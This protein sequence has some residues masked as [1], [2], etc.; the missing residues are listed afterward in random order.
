MSRGKGPVNYFPH[1]LSATGIIDALNMSLTAGNRLGPYEILSLIG[2]GGMGEVYKARDSRLD[3]IVAVKISK[4]EFDPRFEREALAV[5]ALN[6]PHIC[7]LF[8][9]GPHYLVMEYVEGVELAGPMPLAKAIPLACQ[10]LDALDAAHCRGIIHRDLKPANV[11]VTR[12]GVKVLDF[13]LAKIPEPREAAFDHTKSLI[14]AEGMVAG[15]VHYMSPEHMQGRHVDSRADIFAF[16]CVLHELLTG[17]RAFEGAD[18]A[19]VIA[20][21]IEGPTPSVATVAP[22]AL[23]RVLKKCL[24]K[25]R[26]DRWNCARDLKTQL[27]WAC[28]EV[29]ATVGVTAPEPPPPPRLLFGRVPME[30]AGWLAAAA[31]GVLALVAGVGVVEWWRHR[32]A[33]SDA[34]GFHVAGKFLCGAGRG[35][36]QQPRAVQRS[37]DS[38]AVVD[39]VNGPA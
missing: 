32:S 24:A 33:A 29:A 37:G 15:T 6:H 21:V 7:T 30:R 13:G 34:G 18:A 39:A 5:A 23:D 28:E 27:L 25:D 2:A 10:I 35:A 26:E 3:R 8:D 9:V 31:A 17:K 12:A 4:N 1:E 16:G 19:S 22:S 14:T 38:H 36:G 20:K 11:M